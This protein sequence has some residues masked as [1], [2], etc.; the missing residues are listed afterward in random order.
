[1][2]VG[3][4]SEG[5]FTITKAICEIPIPTAVILGNHD[6]GNDDSGSLLRSQLRILGDI[7]C[8]WRQ[9][10]WDSPPIAVIGARPCSSGGGFYLSKS[11]KAVFGPI[12]MQES[13]KRIT[14]AARNVPEDWPL[15]IL[16]HSG[17][18]GLGS[19]KYSPCG[20]DWKA[21]EIDWGDLDLA[22]AIKEIRKTRL[23]DLVVFGHMHHELSRGKGIRNTFFKDSFGT[24]FLNAACVPR[25]G[26]D[27][28]GRII[29]HYTW[30]EFVDSKLSLA[31]H[32]WFY[33]DASIAFQE[34]LFISNK[35]K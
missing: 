6:R 31:A 5:E 4:L 15:V 18:S 17:P 14:K 1:M 10:N 29:S 33:P 22:E 12:T 2:F 20:R 26:F 23:P 35:D 19:D 32:R 25:R 34:T 27:S 21:P 11:V 16:A 7:H 13:A 3:D 9:R 28:N 24:V 30:V 8:G